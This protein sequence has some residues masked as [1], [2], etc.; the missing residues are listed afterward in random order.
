MTWF[1]LNIPLAALFFVAVSGIPLW[2]VLKH[3][4]AGPHIL[5]DRRPARPSATGHQASHAA[6]LARPPAGPGGGHIPVTSAAGPGRSSS[7]AG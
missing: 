3:P 5:A 6:A 4:E 2:M 7:P 1:W